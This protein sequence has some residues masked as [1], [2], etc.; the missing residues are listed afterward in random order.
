MKELEFINIIKNTLTD[1]SFIGDDTAFAQGFVFTQD[2]LVEDVHFRLSTM[3]AFELAQKAVAVNLSDIAASGGVPC[4]ILISLSLP[5]YLDSSFVEN[6]YQGVEQSCSKYGIKVLGGDI[7]GSDK[8]FVSICAVGKAKKQ[9]KRSFAKEGD[10]IFTT[11][12]HGSSKAGLEILEKTLDFDE[13]FIQAHKLP[14]PKIKEGA[15]IAEVC[16]SP[17]LMDSSDGLLDA[18]YKIALASSVT[19]EVDFDSVPY[20]FDIKKLSSDWY[21]WVLFGGEDYELVG[22]AR[23]SDFAGLQEVLSLYQI[24]HVVAKSDFPVIIK[25]DGDFRQITKEIIENMSFDHFKK[26]PQ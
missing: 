22:C 24:G 25:K 4:Y 6:F 14:T 2:T 1:S 23:E 26:G 13:K 8:V 11:G 15:I 12:N 20:D 10:V 5:S 21:N 18:L 3:S 16:D 9:I 19:L 7:T 17:A